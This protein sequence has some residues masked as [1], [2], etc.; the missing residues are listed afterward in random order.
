MLYHHSKATAKLL[1]GI[2]RALRGLLRS[3]ERLRLDGVLRRSLKQGSPKLDFRLR[4]F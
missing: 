2:L 4:G 3:V 1:S